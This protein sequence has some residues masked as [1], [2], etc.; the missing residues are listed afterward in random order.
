MSGIVDKAGG[1]SGAC[2]LFGYDARCRQK[3]QA[4]AEEIHL[5]S[6]K[7]FP[8]GKV[9][10]AQSGR[11]GAAVSGISSG[12][13]VAPMVPVQPSLEF[14]GSSALFSERSRDSGGSLTAFFEEPFPLEA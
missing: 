2:V 12:A 14:A 4:R 13:C 11:R 8:P 6:A 3:K 5:L 7:A 1:L 9:P 10:P